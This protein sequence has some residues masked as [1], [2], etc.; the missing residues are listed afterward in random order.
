MS[1]SGTVKE[2]V[3][4][5]IFQVVSIPGFRMCRGGQVFVSCIS[6][7]VGMGLS[8]TGNMALGTVITVLEGTVLPQ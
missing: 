5:V 4:S 2:L 6:C 1:P 7:S 3:V 8:Y